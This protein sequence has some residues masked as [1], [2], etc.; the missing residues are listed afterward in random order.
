MSAPEVVLGVALLLSWA[1]V[2]FQ[3][4][5]LYLLI[6]QHGR[7][8]IAGDEQR[9]Q[10]VAPVAPPAP[11]PAPAQPQGLALGSPA[12]DFA[13]RDLK[14]RQRKLRDYGG[15]STLLVFFNPECGFCSQMAPQLAELA[16]TG[17]RL[18][19]MSRGDRTVHMR[20]A[21]QY[22]WKFD[23]LVE[24]GWQV[25]TSYGT[26]AT[27]TGY[28]IDRGGRIASSLAVG[29]PG[30][31][32]L[33]KIEV[34]VG[35][36]PSGPDL[37]A[38]S[39]RAKAGV[40]AEK[41]RGAGLGIRESTLNRN[42]LPAGTSAPNFT[43]PDLAGGERTLADYRGRR[44]LLVF[45]DPACGPC[46]AL[47]PELERLHREHAQNNLEVLVVSRGDREAN[48]SKAKEQS[49]TFPVLLQNGWETSREYAM[50]ATPIGYLIDERGVTASEVAV[51]KDAVIALVGAA[52]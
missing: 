31:V 6:K 43:L 5:L 1:I 19:L 50:F 23:I 35:N 30:I 10:A 34:G 47:A 8:L 48:Q 40:A 41:A 37:T 25:A 27:P 2:G 16:S 21:E 7:M 39:L 12:P 42:G 11:A 38:E 26:N 52:V 18:V 3:S 29:A 49:L 20:L 33:A 28:L 22:G 17:P 24:D 51:G 44:V 14:G 13:L 32:E 9:V 4:W 36:G 15:K 45:S 46:Q